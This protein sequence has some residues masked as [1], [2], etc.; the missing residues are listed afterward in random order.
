MFVSKCQESV[1]LM[2]TYSPPPLV[3]TQEAGPP[4]WESDSLHQTFYFHFFAFSFA[5]RTNIRAVV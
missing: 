2:K 4:Q 1:W 5:Y 3:V